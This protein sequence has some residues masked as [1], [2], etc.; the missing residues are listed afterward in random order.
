MFS[1]IKKK[2]HE[3]GY[4]VYLLKENYNFEKENFLYGDYIQHSL[5]DFLI[6]HISK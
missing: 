1:Y 2:P 3:A 6:D 5:F 4:L